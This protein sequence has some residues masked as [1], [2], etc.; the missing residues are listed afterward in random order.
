MRKWTGE[1]NLGM[2]EGDWNWKI[3]EN[4]E[5]SMKTLELYS[6]EKKIPKKPNDVINQDFFL[7]ENEN[8]PK[9]CNPLHSEQNLS[10]WGLKK[11]KAETS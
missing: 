8:F 3:R 7:A 5:Y 10:L 11:K 4:R 1:S 6:I 2:T 9:D